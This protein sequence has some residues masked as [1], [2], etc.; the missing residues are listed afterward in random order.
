[1]DFPPYNNEPSYFTF[2]HDGFPSLYTVLLHIRLLKDEI[3]SLHKKIEELSKLITTKINN[4]E[5]NL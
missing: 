4:N 3:L 1:M 2:S 5:E